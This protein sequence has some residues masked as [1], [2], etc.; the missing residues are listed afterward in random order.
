MVTGNSD[1][2]WERYG[3]QFP[4]FGV[5]TE[6]K[7]RTGELSESLLE[8]FFQTGEEDIRSLLKSVRQHL[9]M[10]FKPTRALDFGCGVGRLTIPLAKTGTYVVGVDI[11]DSMLKEARNN[12]LRNDVVAKV[13]LVKSDERLTK[14]LGTFDFMI[15]HIVFQHIPPRRGNYILRE[16]IDRLDTDGVGVLHF[17]FFRRGSIIR[18]RYIV[19]WTRK[20]VPFANNLANLIQKKPFATPLMQWNN[21]NLN[22]IFSTL[23]EKGCSDCYIRFT[24]HGGH[25][26]VLI[27]FQKKALPPT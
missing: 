8:E 24:D 20:Y 4:Y 23:Q 9:D 19:Q 25:L 15:S 11:S 17:T 10:N 12:C 14:V 26:G 22:Y 3:K 6:D 21:Y 27:F 16:M 7:Y 2:E 18:I 5:L 1:V 13:D